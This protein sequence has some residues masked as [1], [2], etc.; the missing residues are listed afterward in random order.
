MVISI[1]IGAMVNIG[2]IPAKKPI[3]SSAILVIGFLAG[4]FA[5][6]AVSKMYEI[7]RVIFGEGAM[8]KNKDVKAGD[9]K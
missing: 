5:D 4:Y 9:A 3:S 8:A 1:V 7:A 6:E 2:M